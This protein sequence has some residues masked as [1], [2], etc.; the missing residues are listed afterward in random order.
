M[1]AFLAIELRK[2]TVP[3]SGTVTEDVFQ[4]YQDTLVY[5]T[6]AKNR[7]RSLAQARQPLSTP[8]RAISLLVGT[9]NE[10]S[11]RIASELRRA[12][13]WPDQETKVY[14]VDNVV[15][16][17]RVFIL[18]PTGSPYA[19][20]WWYIFVTFPDNYPSGPPVFRFITVPCTLR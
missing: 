19:G 7:I 2:K 3:F 17:W 4:Q 11:A 5:D 1:E 14:P 16:Q 6:D 8:R 10:R 9:R 15:D 20:K 18:G 13:N 12:F